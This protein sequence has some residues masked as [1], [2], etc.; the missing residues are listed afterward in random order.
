MRLNKRF[1][2]DSFF[3]IIFWFTYP[4]DDIKI[5]ICL[6][7]AHKLPFTRRLEDKQDFFPVIFLFHRI[8][9]HISYG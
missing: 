9:F 6:A 2:S 8:S 3:F 1:F 7:S 5:L 4:K